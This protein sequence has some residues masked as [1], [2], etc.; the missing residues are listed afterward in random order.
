[1]LLSDL[2]SG[3]KGWLKSAR[4]GGKVES[5]TTAR[6]ARAVEHQEGPGFFARKQRYFF[7]LG[8][9]YVVLIP[10]LAIPFVQRH[11]TYQHAIRYP[12][13]ANYSLPEKY[14]LAH[15]LST[16]TLLTGT[17]EVNSN[18]YWQLLTAFIARKTLNFKLTATDTE[19][20]QTPRQRGTEAHGAWFILSDLMHHAFLPFSLTSPSTPPPLS[21]TDSRTHPRSY[22]CT[23]TAGT[24]VLPWHID[25]YSTFITRLHANI[26]ALD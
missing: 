24:R 22:T 10:L 12:F 25:T 1:M 26:L 3:E 9:L 18:E 6:K 23:G 19:A 20:T 16:H 4:K 7:R 5:S 15:S 17:L 21:P 13:F 14:G 11:V 8:I 2:F